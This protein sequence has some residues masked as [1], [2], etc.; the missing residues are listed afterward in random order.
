MA[1]GEVNKINGTLVKEAVE[2]ID[3]FFISDAVILNHFVHCLFN[4]FYWHFT[5]KWLLFCS[6]L[7][8]AV[9]GDLI[10]VDDFAPHHVSELSSNHSPA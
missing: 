9:F 3:E 4:F 6:H 5:F 7:L 10:H 8:F 2:H 1:N